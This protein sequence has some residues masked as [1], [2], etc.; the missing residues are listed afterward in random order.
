MLKAVKD[1]KLNPSSS[2]YEVKLIL[3]S[4]QDT[5]NLAQKLASRVKGGD[6]ICLSGDLGT[7]KTTFCKSFIGSF[8][9]RP[10]QIISPTFN[11]LQTFDTKDFT[12]WHYDFYR[13]ENENE[14]EELGFNEALKNGM[15]IIEW[16]EIVEKY[17]PED[18]LHIKFF[19]GERPENRV[20]TITGHGFWSILIKE[21]FS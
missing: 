11:I 14:L 12:I 10:Q 15:C 9:S 8:Y 21:I 13:I 18:R 6:V 19:H 3:S 4:L 16:P 2:V 5:H 1:N 7:G 20:V 17:L